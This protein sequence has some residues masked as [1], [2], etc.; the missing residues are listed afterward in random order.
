MT[1]A[2]LWLIQFPASC[3]CYTFTFFFQM[4]V[5][6]TRSLTRLMNLTSRPEYLCDIC[7]GS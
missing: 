6:K 5:L 1:F 3:F 4:F 2:F 7:N